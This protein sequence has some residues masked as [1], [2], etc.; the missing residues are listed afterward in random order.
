MCRLLICQWYRQVCLGSSFSYRRAGI[1]QRQE[2]VDARCCCSC[3]CFLKA[4][5]WV[6]SLSF[7][8]VFKLCWLDVL[9][10]PSEFLSHS[11]LRPSTYMCVPLIPSSYLG[12]SLFAGRFSYPLCSAG[13]MLSLLEKPKHGCPVSSPR[14]ELQQMSS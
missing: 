10:W 9:D 1:P 5:T 6:Y 3:C 2:N 14:V 12:N 8:C 4:V 11:P 13:R 7:G